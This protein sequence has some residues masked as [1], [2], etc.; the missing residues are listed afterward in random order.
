[1]TQA[2][3]SLEIS[4]EEFAST[5]KSRR[6]FD[7]DLASDGILPLL[8]RTENRGE[9]AYL[10]SQSSIKAYLN[11]RELTALRGID[12]ARNVAA[13]S[14]AGR[15]TAWTLATGPLALLLWPVTISVSAL[16][17]ND[18]N[19]RIDN[20]FQ[21]F[22]LGNVLAKPSR[23]VGGFLFFALPHGAKA[24]E[25]LTVEV[26]LKP[27]NGSETVTVKLVF[28]SFELPKLVSST[29]AAKNEPDG[30]TDVQK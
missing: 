26:P 27:Q 29:V 8:L 6:A 2:V 15:A 12:V 13:R 16:H 19:H 28:P 5:E 14:A 4:A 7:T 25:N 20:H 30:S 24:I 22:D 23:T 9:P 18:V 3:G 1:M 11:G 17:T 21:N 10:V